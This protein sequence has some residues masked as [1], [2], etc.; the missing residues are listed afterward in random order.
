MHL[1][2]MVCVCVG[3]CVGGGGAG[4]RMKGQLFWGDGGGT[5][6]YHGGKDS[7]AICVH[8]GVENL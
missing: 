3:V 7:Y 1:E 5:R 8:A 2:K 6:F 4:G